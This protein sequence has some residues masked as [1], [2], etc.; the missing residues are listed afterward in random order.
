M[1]AHNAEI[2]LIRG[3]N[4]KEVLTSEVLAKCNSFEYSST[5]SI[6]EFPVANFK[7][8]EPETNGFFMGFSKGD[9]L[10]ISIANDNSPLDVVFRGEFLQKRTNF[11]NEEKSLSL[12]IQAVHSFF[13]LQFMEIPHAIDI[14]CNTLSDLLQK[15]ML[16]ANVPSQITIDADVDQVIDIGA[17]ERLNAFLLIKMICIQKNICISF[18]R[19]NSVTFSNRDTKRRAISGSAPVTT[20][21]ASDIIKMEVV[22]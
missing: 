6:G 16:P 14:K 5:E 10:S 21:N 15:I 20:L 7:S 17:G 18:N 8:S 1:R 3:A 4:I 12:D 13:K 19:D 11:N 22:E 9:I 2:Q